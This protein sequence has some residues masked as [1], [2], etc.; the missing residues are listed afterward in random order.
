LLP[1]LQTAKGKAHQIACVNNLKQ[2]TLFGAMY[3][4][5]N[6]GWMMQA[7]N[8]V[9]WVYVKYTYALDNPVAYHWY[10]LL[11]Y[12]GYA[13]GKPYE[14][15]SDLVYLADASD[16]SHLHCPSSYEA[17]ANENANVILNRTN[18]RTKNFYGMIWGGNGRANHFRVGA[19]PVVYS[20]YYSSTDKLNYTVRDET[21]WCDGIPE[22][23]LLFCDSWSA[24]WSTGTYYNYGNRAHL[25]YMPD[26]RHLGRM[27]ASYAD[28][29]V[30]SLDVA[31][32]RAIGFSGYRIANTVVQ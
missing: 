29:H 17:A 30:E 7:D 26:L 8:Y 2:I 1:A 27:P 12:L 18:N 32:T 21:T 19:A 20:E 24:Q 28:G 4:D 16:Q 22:R 25:G 6:E 13:P 10:P 15:S 3:M 31:G 5:D 14:S 9:Y 11:V 23:F